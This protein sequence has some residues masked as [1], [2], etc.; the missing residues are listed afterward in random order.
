MSATVGV[1]EDL[2]S[3]F[4][5]FSCVIP[6]R[7]TAGANHI[8]IC[9]LDFIRSL[10]PHYAAVTID[11]GSLMVKVVGPTSQEKVTYCHVGL[12]PGGLSH[13]PSN[14]E[15]LMR[16]PGH[17]TLI[18][19]VFVPPTPTSLTFPVGVNSQ[20]KPQP[21]YGS[22][23]ELVYAWH[24]LGSAAS[25]TALIVLSGTLRVSGVGFINPWAPVITPASTTIAE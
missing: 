13:W 8:D 21:Y 7:G 25:A 24:L 22:S 4:V 16:L 1:T 9:S 6:F 3:Q 23:L 12:V 5:P 2:V 11:T 19:S 18:H 10:L 17:Q 14:S 15:E 20:L